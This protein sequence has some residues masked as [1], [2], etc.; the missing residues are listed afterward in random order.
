[1]KRL[2]E[3]QAS[4]VATA[5]IDGMHDSKLSLCCGPDATEACAVIVGKR[6]AEEL[7]SWCYDRLGCH[8]DNASPLGIYQEETIGH[9]LD[10]IVH[11]MEHDLP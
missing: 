1:M 4:M 10:N 9:Y 5:M 3:V 6:R 2:T 11:A 7:R 8:R